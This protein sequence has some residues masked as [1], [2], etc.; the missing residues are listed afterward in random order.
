MEVVVLTVIEVLGLDV[1]EVPGAIDLTNANLR[2]TRGNWPIEPQV[3]LRL[4]DQ[5]VT[6]CL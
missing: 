3:P 5:P 6:T 1:L 4:R 2:L